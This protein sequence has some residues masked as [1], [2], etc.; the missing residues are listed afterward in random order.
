MYFCCFE[1]FFLEIQRELLFLV[2]K[3]TSQKGAQIYSKRLFFLTSLKSVNPEANLDLFKQNV[4]FSSKWATYTLTMFFCWFKAFFWEIHR[5]LLFL[6]K[7][8]AISKTNSEFFFLTCLKRGKSWGK[9]DL[10]K[11]IFDQTSKRRLI[12]I[13]KNFLH[14]MSYIQLNCAFLLFWSIFGVIH[15][16]LQF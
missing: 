16:E 12:L 7:K 2:Q 1:A 3:G 13:K 5:E 4:F 8:V 11:Q 10:F 15:R 14:K 9:L 6:V